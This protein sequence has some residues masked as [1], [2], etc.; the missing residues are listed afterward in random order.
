MYPLLLSSAC[1]AG[2]C[3]HQSFPRLADHKT[4][5][6]TP[7]ALTAI[8]LVEGSR[9][10]SK[11]AP[12]LALL[13]PQLDSLVFWSESELSELQASTVVHKIGRA[14]AEEAFAEH[15]FPLGLSNG[16]LEMCHRVASVIMSYA[17]DIPEKSVQED[18]DSVEESDDLV[19]D[20]EENEKTIL[21]M[22]PLADMLVSSMWRAFLEACKEPL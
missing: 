5:T 19:S 20:D 10:D 15:I 4:L 22:I 8:I 16:N 21:S 11:W 1:L 14:N 7:Q 13:P 9:E 2:W 12:Y 6:L 3:A 17:F 18:I